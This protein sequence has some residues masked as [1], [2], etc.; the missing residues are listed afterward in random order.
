MGARGPLPKRSRGVRG[1]S[2]ALVKKNRG[3]LPIEDPHWSTV[4]TWESLALSEFADRFTPADYATARR[5]LLLWDTEI[6]KSRWNSQVLMLAEKQLEALGCSVA[7]RIRLGID[8]DRVEDVSGV[9]VAGMIRAKL[10]A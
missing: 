10:E 4:E 9:D 5:A 3:S 2:L 6:R 8:E 1:A 7:A